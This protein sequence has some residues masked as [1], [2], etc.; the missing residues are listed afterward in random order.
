FHR[1]EKPHPRAEPEAVYK[2]LQSTAL[3]SI[4]DEP[5]ARLWHARS[6]QKNVA[7]SLHS[8]QSAQADEAHLAFTAR[9]RGVPRDAYSVVDDGCVFPLDAVRLRV[10]QQRLAV[11]HHDVDARGGDPVD[12]GAPPA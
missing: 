3:G 11:G 12:Q 2:V 4:A 1:A 9:D 8:L 7:R 10:T 6:G 5:H